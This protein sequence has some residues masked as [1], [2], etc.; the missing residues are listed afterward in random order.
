VSIT[1][2]CL[3]KDEDIYVWYAI[4]S[5]IDY[6]DKMI[7][8]DTGSADNTQ[9]IIKSIKNPKIIYEEKGL[10]T[11]EELSK[12]RNEMIQKTNTEWIFILD[13]DE[14]WHQKSIQEVVDIANKSKDKDIVVNPVRML[15]GDIFH[16]QE[17][18]AGKYRIAD[19]KG[20]LNIRLINRRILGLR[21]AGKYPNE[22]YITGK[23]TKVQNL[24]K[25][26]MAFADNYYLHAS[27]LKRSSKKMKKIKYEIGLSFPLDYYYPEVFFKKRPSYILSPWI[28][29][30]GNYKLKAIIQTPLKKI[31]R[32][33]F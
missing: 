3:V 26:K 30:D 17:E 27:F 28:T 32:R 6:V 8:W 1:A 21:V 20:H 18:A 31:K 13:G 15:V 4:N 29:N 11:A 12:L 19:K 7:I 24:S 33:L 16:Y 14:I 22:A 2:H 5:V 9:K 23:G 10:K 25:S